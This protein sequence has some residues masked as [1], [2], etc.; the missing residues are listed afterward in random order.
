MKIIFAL[1]IGVLCGI[2]VSAQISSRPRSVTGSQS[3]IILADNA[4]YEIILLDQ[5]NLT[6]KLDRYTGKTYQYYVDGR[7][8]WY[9]LEV[10]AGLP[11]ESKNTTPK[12]QIIGEG[13]SVF[14]IN[15]ETGQS[16]IF[17]V[18]TWEPVTD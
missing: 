11:D 5:I 7:R 13:D 12:Y 3:Q 10:R 4:R 2:S 16:W 1:F 9:P 6:V 17:N 8:R 18:R 14:L 15:N